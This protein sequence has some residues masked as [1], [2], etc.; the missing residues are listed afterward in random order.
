M[1]YVKLKDLTQ[2]QYSILIDKTKTAVEIQLVLGCGIA[3]ISRWRKK[4]G[5]QPPK[6]SK[7]NKPKPW[8]V[9]KIKMSCKVCKK[10]V[11]VVPC[12]FNTF[13]YCSKKCKFQCEDYINTLR[14]MDKSYMQTDQYRQSKR[15]PDTPEYRKYR[16]RVATLTK[17]T[18]NQYKDTIN[19][20]EYTRSIAG[21]VGGYHLD[22]IVSCRE[23][24]ESSMTPEQISDVSNLQML[25]WRD[26]VVKGRK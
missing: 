2:E 16:N 13:K 12:N 19:P 10:L 4:L 24:F 25:P 17:R 15:K 5:A 6:G 26:N 22:H 1:S 11:D 20:E 3:T 21:V 23:G 18:Y 9:T 7:P 8:Q 14:S